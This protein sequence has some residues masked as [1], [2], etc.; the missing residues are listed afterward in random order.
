MTKMKT[1]YIFLAIAASVALVSCNQFLEIPSATKFD[2]DTV[3]Q[4]EARAE[5][6][7]MGA[8]QVGWSD[9]IWYQLG[10]GTDEVYSTEGVTNSKYQ[11][12][13]YVLS[14][15]RTGG[16]FST[17]YK[18]V[19]Q[20]NVCIQ[21]LSNMSEQTDNVKRLLGESYAL[22][23]A[24]YLNL[25][26]YWGDVPYM[27]EP[28]ANQESFYSSRESR[29][30]IYDGIVADLQEAVS[31]LPWKSEIANFTPE[32]YCKESA[33]GLLARVALYAAG[34]SLRWDLDSYAESSLK[35]AKR[36]DAACVKELNK[37]AMDACKAVMDRGSFSLSPKYDDIFRDLVNGR[38]NQ[39]SMLEQGKYGNNVK[40]N[41]GYTNGASC[42][43]SSMFGKAFP[44]M[45]INPILYFDYAEGDTRRDVTICQYAVDA[46]SDLYEMPYGCFYIGKFRPNWKSTIGTGTSARDIN[47]PWLRY[48]HILLMYAEA[49]NEYNG[50]P[51]AAAQDALRQVRSRAF[52][53]DASKI[54]TIPT[55][56]DEFLKAIIDENRFEFAGESW[57]RTEL[58]RWG[59]LYETLTNN[60][61][62]LMKL[63]GREGRYAEVDRYRIFKPV[64]GK[65]LFPDN[66][67]PYTAL[68]TLQLTKAEIDAY[69]A[70]GYVVVDMQD[71]VSPCTHADGNEIMSY[72][73]FET[74]TDGV[75]VYKGKDGYEKNVRYVN[76]FGGLVHKH[77]EILP[78]ATN[79]MDVNVGLKEQQVPGY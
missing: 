35:I 60:K 2:S 37:I 31:L 21:G 75:R 1:K 68:K 71:S 32:R 51:D 25:L 47:W 66:N 17:F 45:R 62:E 61:A 43:A 78:L 13:N 57:R 8:Y 18:A 64:E 69:K 44:Q 19:E 27:T 14:A 10:M 56:H 26:R 3:F 34:Y 7:V 36:D 46:N 12:G 38:Y 5:M 79:V 41:V 53:G 72:G 76:L 59:I 22:R 77:S 30:V 67:I 52:G 54:G 23:A 20:A 15:G 11:L 28:V 63:A 50:A 73:V 70:E 29:D 33:Y 49:S 6:A 9:E 42:H 48:D 65:W 4:T 39:E 74:A 40:C 24:S 58:A 16:C 55:G